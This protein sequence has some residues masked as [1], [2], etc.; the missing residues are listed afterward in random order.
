MTSWVGRAV[1]AFYWP[2]LQIPPPWRCQSLRGS[3]GEAQ[4]RL[5]GPGRWASKGRRSDVGS[6]WGLT[7]PRPASATSKA[8]AMPKAAWGWK[9]TPNEP[10]DACGCKR[11]ALPGYVVIPQWKGLYRTRPFPEPQNIKSCRAC[12][13]A[14]VRFPVEPA[15]WEQVK[16]RPVCRV[17]DAVWHTGGGRAVGRGLG[18]RV[19]K[20]CNGGRNTSC[21]TKPQVAAETIGKCDPLVQT[22]AKSAGTA[23]FTQQR[24]PR[25][26]CKP[27]LTVLRPTFSAGILPQILGN[28]CSLVKGKNNPP[29]VR[30]ENFWKGLALCSPGCL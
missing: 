16:W 9:A 25:G 26:K 17:K 5:L 10:L 15:A 4:S 27:E 19:C 21:K 6:G 8:P 1:A 23:C 24:A 30:G 7:R 14:W 11:W 12:W 20:A 28:L 3:H 22:E 2:V 18:Q 29:T 13:W